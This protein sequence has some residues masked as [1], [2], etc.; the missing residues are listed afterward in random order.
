MQE[1]VELSK[2]LKTD[3][4]LYAVQNDKSMKE[5]LL[6]ATQEILDSD[7]DVPQLQRA[8]EYKTL[9]VDVPGDVKD[10][11]RAFCIRKEVRLRDFWNL[12]VRTAME[13]YN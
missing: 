11:V 8:Q 2:Q 9:I 12:A 6:N 4:K 13:A 7:M 3:F 5:L 1:N 10:Q